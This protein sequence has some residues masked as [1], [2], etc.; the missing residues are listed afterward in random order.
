LH[1]NVDEDSIREISATE[2]ISN[3]PSLCNLNNKMIL[4]VGG[5]NSDNILIFDLKLKFSF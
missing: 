3:N 4:F 2:E 1:I 5:N